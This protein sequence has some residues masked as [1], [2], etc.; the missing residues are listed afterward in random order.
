MFSILNS[1]TRTV[2]EMKGWD[3]FREFPP[4]QDSG[5]MESQ[6]CLEVTVRGLKVM[7]YIITFIVVLA[8]GVIAKGSVFFM[9][10][11]LKKDRRLTYCNRNLGKLFYFIFS[12]AIPP[13]ASHDTIWV[14]NNFSTLH[15]KP[16]KKK[17]T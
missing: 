15:C 9:T 5:S 13:P 8:S 14:Y 3:V 6:K 1:S 16:V 17:K 4:K 12:L 2:Q 10:S 11:Q 7:A